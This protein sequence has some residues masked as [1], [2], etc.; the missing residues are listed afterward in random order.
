VCY[1]TKECLFKRNSHSS[2]LSANQTNPY[3]TLPCVHASLTNQHIPLKKKKK[4][5]EWRDIDGEKKSLHRWWWDSMTIHP[6]LHPREVARRERLPTKVGRRGLSHPPFASQRWLEGCW[7]PMTHH[8]IGE[9]GSQWHP[10]TTSFSRIKV[11]KE[12]PLPRG[13]GLECVGRSQPTLEQERVGH[14]GP[15]NIWLIS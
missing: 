10:T 8:C 6:H 13:G 12:D 14:V 4:K 11:A 2:G 3:Q 1:Q 9:S 5:N 7:S 15:P